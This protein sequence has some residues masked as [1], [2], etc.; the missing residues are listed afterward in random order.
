MTILTFASCMHCFGPE[1]KT[2]HWHNAGGETLF[3]GGGKGKGNR[4]RVCVLRS[5]RGGLR[6]SS[7]FSKLYACF[8]SE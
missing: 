6:S 5:R 2:S 4:E 1:P 7:V 3:G 8:V